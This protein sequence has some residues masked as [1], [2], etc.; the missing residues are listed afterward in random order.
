MKSAFN[1]YCT[2]DCLNFF[3]TGINKITVINRERGK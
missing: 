1:A 3:A 2:F